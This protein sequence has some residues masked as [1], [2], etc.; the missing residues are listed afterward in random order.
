MILSGWWWLEPWNL[1]TFPFSWEW[2]IIPTD[3]SIFF[4]GVG[5]PPTSSWF[6]KIVLLGYCT[7][8]SAIWYFLGIMCICFWSMIVEQGGEVSGRPLLG[9]IFSTYLMETLVLTASC[10]SKDQPPTNSVL[11]ALWVK[12]SIC[13]SKWGSWLAKIYIYISS[14]WSLFGELQQRHYAQRPSAWR[15]LS[16]CISTQARAKACPKPW[17]KYEASWVTWRRNA[18]PGWGLYVYNIYIY[19][20][21]YTRMIQQK[22]MSSQ[23]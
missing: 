23:D 2:K 7:F 16:I 18:E 11:L 10:P 9:L 22:H 3:F 13:W 14:F 12:C 5:I 8:L 19:I 15:S 4:R 1:M 21:T 17:W 20:Y 6:R